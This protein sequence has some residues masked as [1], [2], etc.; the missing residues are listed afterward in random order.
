MSKKKSETKISS[1]VRDLHL[2]CEIL[3][4][5]LHIVTKKILRVPLQWFKLDIPTYKSNVLLLSFV[6]A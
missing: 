5:H 3:S 4:W 1:S 2:D 6:I